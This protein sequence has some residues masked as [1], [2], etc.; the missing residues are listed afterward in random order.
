MRSLVV[1]IVLLVAVSL[2][3]CAAP[4]PPPVPVKVAQPA[5]QVAAVEVVET[6]VVEP[7]PSVAV[8]VTGREPSFGEPLA[9]VTW[10]IWGD[11]ECPF[12][13]KLF[14]RLDAFRAEYGEKQLRVVWRHN[15]LPHHESAPFFAEAAEIVFRLGGSKAFWLFSRRLFENQGSV[16][17][18]GL[19]RMVRETGV[20]PRVFAAEL[21]GGA[22]AAKVEE[23]M[24]VGK[25]AGVTGTPASFI[26]GVFLSG[27][28]PREK[29]V[30][31]LDAEL[32]SARALAAGGL[33]PEKVYAAA[34]EKNY[35]KPP[36]PKPGLPQDTTTVWKVALGSSPVRGKATAQVTLVLF[37]DFECV[38]CAKVHKTVTALEAEY[39]EKL[40][41]VFKHHPQSFHKRAEPAAQLA[42][43][44]RAQGGDARFWQAYDLLL[45]NRER[46]GD[47]DLEGYAKT[48]GIDWKRASAAITSHEHR[49]VID[50]DIDLADEL[51][52]IGTPHFFINGRRLIGSQPISMFRKIIDEEIAAT[53]RLL[54]SG[55]PPKKL[56]ET[57]QKA[58][59]EPP[60]PT[61]ILVPAPT[62]ASPGK[63]A[64]M[65]PKV[66][67]VQMFADFQ[68]PFCKRVEGT[69]DELVAAFPGKV[70]VVWRHRPLSI[71]ADAQLASEAAAEAFAQ[72]GDAGFWA[73]AKLLWADQSA[74]DK[75]SLIKKATEAGL[76]ATKMRAA[77]DGRTH[78]ATVD[79]DAA[80]AASLHVTGT[81]AFAVG[82]YY[83]VGAHP[84][85][86]FEKAVRRALGPHTPPAPENIH[87]P[88][89]PD[90]AAGAAAPAATR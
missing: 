62:A 33:G 63:G 71:H 74:L 9:P 60:P 46:L 72:K 41:L 31:V 54:A 50:A 20:D 79:A 18:Q 40:R 5:P 21:D 7:E 78:K 77:L 89:K 70:R 64:K 43:E 59:K 17:P 51:Q 76:D 58:G 30:A 53:D 12:T 6:R 48:L 52:A 15:P 47:Q 82:D 16:D 23:D 75:E 39:G 25:T 19:L 13:A 29:F 34:V 38:F 22:H 4:V 88:A 32:T 80:L 45:P 2:L 26:N 8:P 85:H 55:T 61:R 81:P 35:R 73:Y 68:C 28:Q 37:G 56:Y 90:P 11:Y 3:A 66:V 24:A 49:K 10:V 42:I 57:L 1:R 67:V 69:M 14:L 83:V 86:K 27:N 44:A 87:G 65:G 84:L 36:P